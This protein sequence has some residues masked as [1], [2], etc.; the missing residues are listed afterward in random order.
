M[1]LLE[2]VPNISEGRRPDIVEALAATFHDAA[3]VTLLDHSSDV[4]HHR[5]VFTA[6]GEPAPV[7]YTHLTL[8]TKA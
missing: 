3:D 7:S 5:S 1:P 4:T 2:V 8:P 6:V